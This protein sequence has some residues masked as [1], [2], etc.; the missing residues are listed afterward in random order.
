MKKIIFVFCLFVINVAKLLAQQTD[1]PKLSGPY[2]GQKP[3]GM[4]PE[5]FAPGIISTMYHEH[6][7]PSFSSDGNEVF[8]V[9]Y[10]VG[11]YTYRYTAKILHSK[12]VD[13]KWTR[14]EYPS[15]TTGIESGEAFITY[16]NSS[17]FFCSAK[18]TGENI[19]SR[20]NFDIW[21][22]ERTSVGWS[23]AV[24]IGEP[25][26]TE[27]QE[28]QPTLTVHRTLYYVGHLDGAKNNYGIF[29]SR[30]LRGK[31]CTPEIL[32]KTINAGKVDWTPFISADESYLLW[33]SSRDGGY[34]SGDIYVAFRSKDDEW[35]EV[36]N[37]GP[38]INGKYNE[39]YPS[40]SPD[41]KYLFFVSDRI[42]K[43]LEEPTE[44]SYQELLAVYN[45]PGNGWS[46]VYWVS[47]KIIEELRPKK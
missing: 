10:P 45:T 2:L 42:N 44:M 46:D 33:S 26:N 40:V 47:T 35:S 24:N 1:F 11:N 13:E 19:T 31:Y 5:I 28:M 30:Y 32:P 8:W 15:F 34:G 4:M 3:P 9:S 36:I 39:R 27:N 21:V 29:R 37:L 16:D 20:K 41:G 6:S 25:I 43:K 38:V 18:K 14:P 7:S 22:S 23:S 17:V 12:L